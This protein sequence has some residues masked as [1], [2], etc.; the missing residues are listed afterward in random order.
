[1]QYQ[2]DAELTGRPLTDTEAEHALDGLPGMSAVIGDN[3]GRPDVLATLEAADV[4][5]ATTI[6]VA[7]IERATGRTVT[8]VQVMPTQEWDRRQG[9][10]PIPELVGATEA[11]NM[12]GV[13][14]QRIAQ[15]VDEGKLPARRAGNALVFARGTVEAYGQAHTV[16]SPIASASGEVARGNSAAA[17]A[18]IPDQAQPDIYSGGAAIP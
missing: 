9:F 13:S 3:Q 2:I 10:V 8:G 4:V 12:L 14:R 15:L 16:V 18:A 11:A 5:Q 7:V 6:A 1:M 17:G